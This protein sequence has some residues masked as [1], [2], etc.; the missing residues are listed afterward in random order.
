MNYATGSSTANQVC[1]YEVRMFI[2]SMSP[3]KAPGYHSSGHALRDSG[4]RVVRM[5]LNQLFQ[6]WLTNSLP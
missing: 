1:D 2:L 5:V 3:H 6:L 4:A